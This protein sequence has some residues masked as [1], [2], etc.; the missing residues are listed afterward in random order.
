MDL[1]SMHTP[2]YSH[3]LDG[4]AAFAKV[5]RSIHSEGPSGQLAGSALRKVSTF[6]TR[7]RKSDTKGLAEAVAKAVADAGV[8][9]RPGRFAAN[10]VGQDS[11]AVLG[12]IL[13]RVARR[14]LGLPPEGFGRDLKKGLPPQSSNAANDNTRGRDGADLADDAVEAERQAAGTRPTKAPPYLGPGSAPHASSLAQPRL[15]ATQNDGN[16]DPTGTLAAIKL[17]QRNPKPLVPGAL[18]G[19]AKNANRTDG[20]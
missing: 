3:D 2:D 8:P 18:G 7:L 6:G 12:K 5:L 16:D 17:A 15:P 11:V 1:Q 20:Q 9:I 13:S 19:P 10:G 4:R 14:G